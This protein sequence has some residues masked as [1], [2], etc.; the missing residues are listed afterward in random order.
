M[1]SMTQEQQR[2]YERCLAKHNLSQFHIS[3]IRTEEDHGR[4]GYNKLYLQLRAHPFIKWDGNAFFTAMPCD[5]RCPLVMRWVEA[6]R[7]LLDAEDAIANH[8]YRVNQR[9]SAYTS[10]KAE[11]DSICDKLFTNASAY[12]EA[13]H[14]VREAKRQLD[15]SEKLLNRAKHEYADARNHY[16]KVC[17]ENLND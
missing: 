4:E 14:K 7:R 3:N 6:K 2:L 17:A 8:E 11:Y 1:S 5:Q 13:L 12:T 16:V 9:T 15:W 10:H